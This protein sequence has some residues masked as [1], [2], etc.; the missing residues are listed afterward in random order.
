M[1]NFYLG[2]KKDFGGF[3]LQIN[4]TH[5]AI[6]LW[7][8]DNFTGDAYFPLEHNSKLSRLH[9]ETI[10][11]SD[12]LSFHWFQMCFIDLR[13]FV[14]APTTAEESGG[15]DRGTSGVSTDF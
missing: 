10:F 8:K 6:N 12:E 2:R 13:S 9:W 15:H 14:L 11:D 7:A 5:I 3:D 1:G 4:T